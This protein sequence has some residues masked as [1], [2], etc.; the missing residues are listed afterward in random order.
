MTTE[1]H[2]PFIMRLPRAACCIP[3]PVGHGNRMWL[4]QPFVVIPAERLKA[5]EPGS[6]DPCSA[7]SS[8]AGVLGSR[9]GSLARAVRDDN[10]TVGGRNPDAI[11][12]PCD[13]PAFQGMEQVAMAAP[14]P[15]MERQRARYL[16][17]CRHRPNPVRQG[18]QVIVPTV[19]P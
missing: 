11:A 14:K 18:A 19:V 2:A 3:P 16:H 10:R 6:K 17:D 1:R 15:L 12:L 8:D 5:R 7:F 13:G 4:A 9:I